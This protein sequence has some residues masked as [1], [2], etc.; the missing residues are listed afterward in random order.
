[1]ATPYCTRTLPELLTLIR[2]KEA[3][4]ARLTAHVTAPKSC[5]CGRPADVFDHDRP[6]I[7]HC[8]RCWL[9]EHDG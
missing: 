3:E 4:I 9:A 8:A 2:D 5:D 1:M 7:V 6:W